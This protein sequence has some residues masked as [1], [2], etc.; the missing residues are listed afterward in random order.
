[1]MMKIDPKSGEVTS[2]LATF[3]AKDVAEVHVGMVR[4]TAWHS[5]LV[6][7]LDAEFNVSLLVEIDDKTG[8]VVRAR[9]PSPHVPHH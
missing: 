3:L 6:E 9:R 5:L 8:K 7:V 4:Q 2:T 1:M